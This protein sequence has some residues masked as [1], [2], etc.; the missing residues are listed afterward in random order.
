MGELRES[1]CHKEERREKINRNKLKSKTERGEEIFLQT[2]RRKRGVLGEGRQTLKKKYILFPA[3][4]KGK[5]LGRCSS[6]FRRKK[7]GRVS[8]EKKHNGSSNK[9]IESQATDGA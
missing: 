1:R 6:N 5:H 9:E 8:L 3:D 7:G 2:I 4:G